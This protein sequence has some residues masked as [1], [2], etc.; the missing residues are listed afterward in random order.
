MCVGA[1]MRSFVAAALLL[2]C[3]FERFQSG[4]LIPGLDVWTSLE[5]VQ[6]CT[7]DGNSRDTRAAIPDSIV[8]LMAGPSGE[9]AE[10]S[11]AETDS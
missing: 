11:G 4:A 7:C 3:T 1:R 5:H 8:A 10:E 6:L 2:L 9:G